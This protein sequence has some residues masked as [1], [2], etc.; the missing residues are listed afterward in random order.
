MK[1]DTY[2]CDS[3]EDSA[4]CT[5]EKLGHLKIP[6]GCNYSGTD[7]RKANWV[8]LTEKPENKVGEKLTPCSICKK[9]RGE[10][11]YGDP[12]SPCPHCGDLFP[13]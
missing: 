12:I 1:K 6:D 4:V 7:D 8:K 11:E 2:V 3:C 9:L 13:F 10:D 5:V